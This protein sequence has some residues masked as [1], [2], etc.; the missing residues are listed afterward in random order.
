MGFLTNIQYWAGIRQ[1]SEV[2]PLLLTIV[3]Y[4]LIDK[5]E[6]LQ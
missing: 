2:F 5:K 6:C 4:L 3:I 1:V